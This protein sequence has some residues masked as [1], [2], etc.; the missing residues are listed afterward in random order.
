[1]TTNIPPNSLQ[2]RHRCRNPRCGLKLRKPTDN[3][4]NAFCCH[5]CYFSFYRSRCIVCE[6]SFERKTERRQV[7]GRRKCRN[8]F[9]RHREHYSSTW[10]PGSVLA[11][12][13]SRSADKTGLKIGTFGGRAW[14]KV[15]GPELAEINLRVPLEPELAARLER[16]HSFYREA[17]QKSKRAAARR[18]LIKRRHPPVN[19]LGG[20]RFPG[21]PELDLSPIVDT[22]EWAVPSRWK[23][24]TNAL[25]VD[26]PPIPEFLKRVPATPR[27]VATEE[28]DLMPEAGLRKVA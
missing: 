15:A 3:L 23:P 13:A 16:A 9:R 14:R 10:Y 5:G 7:C 21:A 2:V 19:I 27:P 11:H 8:E 22:P 20:H 18:A 25:M 6:R 4:R 12:N 28:A 24:I 1:V 26:V 17:L